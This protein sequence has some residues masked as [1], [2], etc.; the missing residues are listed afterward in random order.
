MASVEL[1]HHGGA[2]VSDVDDDDT[3]KSWYTDTDRRFRRLT[4]I[5]TAVASVWKIVILVVIVMLIHV[6]NLNIS[7][8]RETTLLL[9]EVYANRTSASVSDHLNELIDMGNH[10]M[11]WWTDMATYMLAIGVGWHLLCEFAIRVI[12]TVCGLPSREQQRLGF[13]RRGV[14][15]RSE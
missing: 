8:I 7:E 11:Q 2:M 13:L 1:K 15:H 14:M 5:R 6:V 9:V 3:Y 12:P 10:D 4:R